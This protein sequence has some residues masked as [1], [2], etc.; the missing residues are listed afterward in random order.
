MERHIPLCDR[1]KVRRIQ[2]RWK[3]FVPGHYRLDGIAVGFLKNVV[4]VGVCFTSCQEEVE[5]VVAILR[6]SHD[7]IHKHSS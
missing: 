4:G 6:L 3:R 5:A 2:F 7:S 1:T